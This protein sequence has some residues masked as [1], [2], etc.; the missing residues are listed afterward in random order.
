MWTLPFFSPTCSSHSL[1]PLTK[2]YHNPPSRSSQKLVSHS[3][4]TFPLPPT[5]NISPSVQ[6]HF[7]KLSWIH[8]LLSIPTATT[9]V[10][11]TAYL[12]SHCWLL[13]N[14]ASLPLLLSPCHSP[15]SSHSHLSN[16]QIRSP[17][18]SSM[19][20]TESKLKF[21]ML[22]MMLRLLPDLAPAYFSNLISWNFPLTQHSLWSS[23]Q[24]LDLCCF[25]AA[26]SAG[27]SLSRTLSLAISYLCLRP[28]FTATSSKRPPPS[29]DLNY[30]LPF[31]SCR[32]CCFPSCGRLLVDSQNPFSLSFVAMEFS[33][34][35][36]HLAKDYVSLLYTQM[37]TCDCFG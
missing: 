35:F 8:L 36:G 15:H 17:R 22:D 24:S 30:V 20:F 12:S 18:H 14:Q 25:K 21:K 7:R 3:Y 32:T 23:H 1:L 26:P 2:V 11:T 33:W 6:I 29:S 37:W 19:D 31:F 34:V 10:R 16:A 28:H 27:K 9:L 4:T 5:L 13:S